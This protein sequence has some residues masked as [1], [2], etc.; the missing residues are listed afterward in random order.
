MSMF[1][2]IKRF[3]LHQKE[4]QEFEK[5]SAIAIRIA[6]NT[7]R[8]NTRKPPTPFIR[9]VQITNHEKMRPESDV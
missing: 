2:K 4:T 8:H 6:C 5:I 1:W 9:A 7:S 3:K